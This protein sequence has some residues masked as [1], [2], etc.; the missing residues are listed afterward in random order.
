[1][2]WPEGFFGGRQYDDRG[3]PRE[4]QAASVIRRPGFLWGR[5]SFLFFSTELRFPLMGRTLGACCSTTWQCLLEPE[6]DV[7]RVTHTATRISTTWCM[8]WASAS[9]Y[10]TAGRP[11]EVD[12]SYS[13][14]APLFPVSRHAQRLS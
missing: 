3:F 8:R 6:P 7:F 4:N 11:G 5:N 12:F 2:R 9:A 10:R 14:N 13:P 1:V